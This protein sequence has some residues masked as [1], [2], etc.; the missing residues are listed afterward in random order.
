MKQNK[1]IINNV[2]T[3]CI[4]W[5]GSDINPNGD[6]DNNGAPRTDP[7]SGHGQISPQ[8]ATSRCHRR[9]MDQFQLKSPYDIQIRRGVTIEDAIFVGAKEADIEPAKDLKM[10][11]RQSITQKVCKRYFDTRMTGGVLGVG[12]CPVESVKGVIT[13]AWGRSVYPVQIQETALTRACATNAAQEKEREMGRSSKVSHGVYR[14]NFFVNPHHAAKNGA[15]TSDLAIYLD[16]IINAYEHNRSVM[17][18]MVN[19]RGMWLFKHESKFGNAP[20]H[21]LIDRVKLDSDKGEDA[22][23]WDDYNLRFDA[24]KLPKGI[25]VLTLEELLGGPAEILKALSE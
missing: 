13:F 11:A 16:S 22:Q 2:F 21:M 8:A 7:H 15:T 10:D 3:A 12:S 20:A 18:G 25:S 17:S 14:Q 23:S 9:V 4:I 6:P 24:A 5:E 1:N 19:I